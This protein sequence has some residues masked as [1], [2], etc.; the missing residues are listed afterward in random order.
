LVEAPAPPR[1]V[2]A[3]GEVGRLRVGVATGRALDGRRVGDRAGVTYGGAFV[4][5]RLGGPDRAELDL[6]RL[7]RAVGLLARAARELRRPHGDA[8]AVQAQVHR[9]RRGRLGLD[10]VAFVLSD[11][12]AERLGGALD[13]LGIE[14]HA[15]ELA[16][17][18]PAFLEADHRRCQ[19]HHARHGRRERGV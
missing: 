1:A 8:G 11:L 7:G 3:L 15:G 9:R 12:A 6:A 2:H 16:H 5:A 4:I 10:H 17:Q 19:P 14:R 13:L 18:L